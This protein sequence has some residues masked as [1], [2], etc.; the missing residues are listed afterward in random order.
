MTYS[1]ACERTGEP[2]ARGEAHEFRWFCLD[3]LAGLDFGFGQGEV[4]ARVLEQS[5]RI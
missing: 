4:V 1:A 3:E 2:E 5:G